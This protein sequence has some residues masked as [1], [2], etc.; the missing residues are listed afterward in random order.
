M[1]TRTL[2][3]PESV[4]HLGLDSLNAPAPYG[5]LLSNGSYITLFTNAGTG[6]SAFRDYDLTRWEAD[7]TEDGNGYFIYV[8]DVHSGDLWSLGY[9]PVCATPDRYEV[10][11]YTHKAH[12]TRWD[13]SLEIQMEVWVAPDDPVELRR[14]TLR[15]H[16]DRHR[17]IELTSF[18]ETVLA[19]RS[20]HAGHPAFSK[21]FI[22][23]DFL[24]AH[25]AL[26]AERRR[27]SAEEASPLMFHW[28][29]HNTQDTDLDYETDRYRFLGRG[30]ELRAP[31]AL[32][33]DEAFSNTVGNVLEPMFSLRTRVE[34]KPHDTQEVTFGLGTAANRKEAATL[35]DR[36][37]NAASVRHTLKRAQAY[38]A[39]ALNRLSL[40]SAQ[41][42][43]FQGVTG[44]LLYGDPR[45]RAVNAPASGLKGWAR[46]LRNYGL[47]G[48]KPLIAAHL[49]EANHKPVLSGLSS[50]YRFLYFKGLSVDLFLLVDTSLKTDI[51]LI[52]EAFSM[53]EFTSKPVRS[54][55]GEIVIR[56]S[57][58]ISADEL[59]EIKVVARLYVHDTF[60]DLEQP[61]KVIDKRDA[62]SPNPPHIAAPAGIHGPQQNMT[63][64]ADLNITEIL[65][66]ENGYGG[67][68][69]DGK[70]YVIRL[71]PSACH[72]PPQPWTNVV[73]NESMGF[74]AS[75]SGTCFTW[76]VNSR[77]HRLTPWYNDP[78]TDP[79]GEA[80]Y[81]RDE[82]AGTYWSPT[83]GPVP[84]VGAY[85]V[86]HG[87][88][89]TRY[90]HVSQRLEQEV[91]L[92]VPRR[93]PLKITRLRL[94]NHGDATREL[95]LFSYQRLALVATAPDRAQFIVTRYDPE[96]HT[97]QATSQS[98]QA[99]AERVA[100]AAV[101]APE[102]HGPVQFTCDRKAFI[103]RNGSPSRP[104]ALCGTETLNGVSGSGLD[105]CFA[106]Q[107]KVA[108]P[109]GESLEC[110]FLL[111][112]TADQD[113]L[114]DLITRYGHVMAL[115]DALSESRVFWEQLLGGV[116]IKTPCPEIDLM[117]N[118]W[119]S[120]QNLSCRIWG[121]SAYYQ[122]GGAFGFRDQLQDAAALVYL[123]PELTRHQILLHAAH[124]FVEG[125]VLH[126]WHPPT[127]AGLRT[128]FSDDLLWLPF[129]TSFYVQATGDR[130]ILYEPVHFIRA[131]PLNRD[132]DES[133]LAPEDSGQSASLYEHCCRALDRSLTTGRHGLPLMGT[134]DWND[135]MNRVGRKGR[136]ESVWLGFF[137]YHIL[138]S[139]IPLCEQKGDEKRAGEYQEYR[140]H[141]GEAL[142]TAGWDGEWYRR[143]YYD[144]GTPLGS[145][146][147]DECRIDALAQAWAVI[148]NAVPPKRAAQAI[149]ALETH[150]VSE[151]D[152]LI[153]L[154]TPPFDQTP[155]DPGYIK[156][157]VPGVRENGGQYTHAA[158]WAVKAI[159]EIGQ[160]SKA[161]SLLAMLS[162]VS[163]TRTL[164]ETEV[165][166]VE[167]YVIAADVYGVPPH[168]G[169]GGWTW[170]TGSAGWMFRIALESILGIKLVEGKTLWL[171]TRMP[172]TW[173]FFSLHYRIP[174]TPTIYDISV[175]NEP[176]RPKHSVT[177]TIDDVPG[178]V[179]AG[180]A[181]IPLVRDGGRHR[182]QL[183]LGNQ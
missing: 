152:G 33:S 93:D 176:S 96:T 16:S 126:W 39:E 109:P 92:Y 23:T 123:R 41:A 183:T 133:Y 168:T 14:C 141:L 83:P 37:R 28:L 138:E 61:S 130:A 25:R 54:N 1:N 135:G 80:L 7:R 6:F 73:A 24:S 116:Q 145:A 15:N 132:E 68:S 88:G 8:R 94:Q 151:E 114:Q 2:R 104:V 42:H 66:Y 161:A 85:E 100:F 81:L 154:L 82:V 63:A 5:C 70:E 13:Q 157:Y 153:R 17:H 165:Y 122:S 111:G 118:G 148:S 129:I 64:S 43:Q 58:E 120:Y 107:L 90:R 53:A 150:L 75:E 55:Q 108:L 98:N 87:F 163:H 45:L 47:D 76:A 173:P 49:T 119:L 86:R 117:V 164:E 4:L 89:Y 182:V 79:H 59:D 105:P 78:V 46:K 170:Y 172:E 158:F 143:A 181:K 69:Q 103:G 155:H 38:N 10:S 30:N 137:I 52:A 12:I 91:C 174:E 50:L 180:M 26:L 51:A 62:N 140:V 178:E 57:E 48:D 9:Q 21:L 20:A 125:D 179:V 128:R 18:V 121:R 36:Y 131:R 149:E 166:R 60:P 56:R 40:A 31:L 142:N 29:I 115:D 169:R 72:R 139:F 74:I 112:E 110:A 144:D 106:W 167:P 99:F 11:F 113:S 22:Q 32:K 77:E 84:D 156:G 95:S 34:L 19:P 3:T 162:P 177:F 159:A 134:G 71:S 35:L 160:L 175:K 127:G 136:G 147:N 97:L 65:R 146:Q 67:F 44:S 102:K 27:R 124:Q 171:R 101:V